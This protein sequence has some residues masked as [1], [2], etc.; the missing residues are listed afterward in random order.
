[1]CELQDSYTVAQKYRLVAGEILSSIPFYSS[2]DRFYAPTD[3]SLPRGH[4][5]SNGPRCLPPFCL[6]GHQLAP[7]WLMPTP[8]P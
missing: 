2:V 8:C 6:L 5:G 4:P 3:D 7:H 1:M